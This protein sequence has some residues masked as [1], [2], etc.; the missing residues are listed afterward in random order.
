QST[1]AFLGLYGVSGCIDGDVRAKHDIAA[2]LDRSAVQNG[3]VVVGKEVFSYVDIEAV[4]A[5]KW[6]FDT[7][8]CSGSS[9]QFFDQGFAFLV[10]LRVNLVISEAGSLG[11]QP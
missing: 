10:M 3:K 2:D 7:E 8:H 11:F 4:V 1:V 6:L 5:V 9:K